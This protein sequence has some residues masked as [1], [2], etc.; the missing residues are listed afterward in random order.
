MSLEH[1]QV[2]LGLDD[3]AP[4]SPDD[5][6]ASQSKVLSQRKLLGRTSKVGNASKDES[7][8]E[9]QFVSY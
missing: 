8:L 1:L 5:T 7:P 6:G 4:A 2:V 9:L 3:Q